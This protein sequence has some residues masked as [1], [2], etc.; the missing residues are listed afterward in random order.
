MS[1]SS[2]IDVRDVDGV[3]VIRFHE[4]QLFDERTV[5]LV[6]ELI[7][8]AL[9]ND[10]TPINVVIDFSDVALISSSMLSKL[11]LLQRRVDASKGKMRL[12]EMSAVVQSVFRT[13]NLDRLFTIDRDQRVSLSAF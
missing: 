5:R 1:A 13:S 11:I 9:P 2:H 3:K 12:C 6:S 7:A 4:H 8:N 10:G